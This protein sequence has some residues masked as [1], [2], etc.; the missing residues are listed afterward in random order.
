MSVCWWT[1]LVIVNQINT[2]WQWSF[3]RKHAACTDLCRE[4]AGFS[5]CWVVK[6][7]GGPQIQAKISFFFHF[8]RHWLQL[9]VP[10][11]RE[12]L[13][14]GL[15]WVIWATEGFKRLPSHQKG[16]ELCMC[17]HVSQLSSS[18]LGHRSSNI[19]EEAAGV[20]ASGAVRRAHIHKHTPLGQYFNLLAS[21]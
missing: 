15:L 1:Y 21:S 2:P 6:R 13:I 7:G 16:I 8:G 19:A 3:I 12:T 11:F 17:L 14:W 4:Y 18:N 5:L 9:C 20:N 10:N